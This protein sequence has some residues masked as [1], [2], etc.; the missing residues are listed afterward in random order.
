MITV[1]YLSQSNVL[2][3][4]PW[5]RADIRGLVVRYELGEWSAA[6]EVRVGPFH[7]AVRFTN[8]LVYVV[9]TFTWLVLPLLAF[10]FVT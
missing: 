5:S 10:R 2:G 4:G 8:C 7:F 6:W 3:G 1:G 9:E